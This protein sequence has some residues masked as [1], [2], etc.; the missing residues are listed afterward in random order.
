MTS[1]ILAVGHDTSGRFVTLD[2]TPRTVGRHAATDLV[3]ADA[4][5]SRRHLEAWRDG[6]RA[7]LRALEGTQPFYF[8]GKPTRAARLAPGEHVIVGSTVLTVLDQGGEPE[9]ASGSAD[10]VAT[11]LEGLAAPVR[12]FA[13]VVRLVELVKD[14]E[15]R[16]AL[17]AAL[18]AWPE[19]TGFAAAVELVDAPAARGKGAAENALLTS[20]GRTLTM[21]LPGHDLA[22]R[23][24]A[25]ARIDDSL[26]AIVLIGAQIVAARLGEIGAR[27][28]LEEDVRALR[29]MSVGSAREFLGDSPAA[30]EVARIV[31]KLAASSSTALLL[32][33]SG[34]GKTFVARLIHEASSRRAAPLRVV[35]CAAIPDA[36]VESELFGAERGAFSGAVATRVGAFEAAGAGTLLLDEIGE[37]PLV[38][39]AKLLRALEDRKFE[40]IGSNRSL[41]L[42]ARVIAATNRDLEG[43][44]ERGTFRADLL[45]RIGVVTVRIPSLRE[46]GDDVV[47]LARRLLSD[48]ATT[49]ARR[50]EGFTPAAVAV[51][52]G[53]SWP[54]N[55]RELRNAIEH[56]LVLGEGDE[57]DADDLPAAPRA[58]GRAEGASAAAPLDP[59]VVRL[60]ADLATLEARAIEAALH[61]T[62]GNRTHAAAL[63]GINRVT[64]QKKLRR[65]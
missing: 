64:L 4:S 45:F 44:V 65:T 39:Q 51:I 58:H 21:Q 35:N 13:A 57:I 61:A 54:G 18:S 30:R 27:S 1:L 14:A 49:A 12:G 63:L 23:V 56:A 52:R 7:E 10:D 36:L 19:R 9:S 29:T 46:R 62:G 26:R 24:E 37:L 17:E 43:M 25:R 42:E 59:H 31:P 40:R 20:A 15:G 50:V 48:L 28:A 34:T 41:P 60:P 53:Y 32:G 5:V 8:R 3:L 6:D 11:M 38:S 22:L 16:R 2:A 47:L 55:V 33:E